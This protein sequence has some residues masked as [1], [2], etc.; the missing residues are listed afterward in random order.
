MLNTVDV[1][2][3]VVYGNAKMTS[4]DAVRCAKINALCSDDGILPT[5]NIEIGSLP[6]CRKCPVQHIKRTNLPS[7][8]L[9]EGSFVQSTC[10]LC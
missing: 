5:K 6:P 3:C 2:T 10:P 7:S 4:V 8:L 1:F 9:D